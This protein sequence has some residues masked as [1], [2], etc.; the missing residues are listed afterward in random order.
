M[1][2][3]GL[4]W[5]PFA[6]LAA[7][8]SVR[9]GWPEAGRA[10]VVGWLQVAGVVPAG[11]D[12]RSGPG[13]RRAGARAGGPGGGR[14]GGLASGCSAGRSSGAGP[15]LVPRLAGGLHARSGRCWW[16]RRGGYLAAAVPYYRSVSVVL[17]IL[18][19]PAA[20]LA[21]WAAWRREP[22]GAL[23]AVAALAV[24]LKLGHL[25]YYVPE[26]NYRLSQGPWGRAVGQWVPPRWP[27]YTFHAWN[28]DLAFATRHPFRQLASPQHLGYQPGEARYVLLLESEYANWPAQAPALIKVADV[29][30]RVRLDPRPGPDRRPRPLDASPPGRLSHGSRTAD[31]HSSARGRPYCEAG[32]AGAILRT[33]LSRGMRN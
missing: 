22:R 17:I 20:A 26:W 32:G 7:S 1:L 33:W 30:G 15:A 11:G 5:T 31:R 8:R 12:V 21:V 9:E 28:H 16:S 27:I 29:P 19:V 24:F 14:G 4:P 2:A 6:A 25:G 18:A 10:L 23:L 13:D 3:L